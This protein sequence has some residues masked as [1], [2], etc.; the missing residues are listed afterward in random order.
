MSSQVQ[1]DLTFIP[2]EKIRDEILNVLSSSFKYWNISTVD[3]NVLYICILKYI[4]RYQLDDPE[5]Y[6]KLN[7]YVLNL[8]LNDK[9][10]FDEIFSMLFKSLNNKLARKISSLNSSRKTNAFNASWHSQKND[11]L[12][13][14]LFYHIHQK[15]ISSTTKCIE[16]I[17]ENDEKWRFYTKEIKLQLQAETE[18]NSGDCPICYT[19]VRKTK[20]FCGHS[21]CKSCISQ[22]VD[23]CC[24]FCREK[25]KTA[26]SF[27]IVKKN[28]SSEVWVQPEEVIDFFPLFNNLKK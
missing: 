21:I 25:I 26:D 7:Q 1:V 17:E 6:Q 12:T 5:L 9:L 23:E 22:I 10:K 13:V 28:I 16:E 2:N 3:K 15:N 8:L 27:K 4:A 20:L 24:P 11:Y 19:N 14:K 18:R